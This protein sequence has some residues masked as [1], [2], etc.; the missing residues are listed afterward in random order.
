MH[1]RLTDEAQR[2]L[3]LIANDMECGAR[4]LRD[5]AEGSFVPPPPPPP[6]YDGGVKRAIEEMVIA[7]PKE[8]TIDWLKSYYAESQL[9]VRAALKRF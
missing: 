7:A 5:I 1:I 3:R 8:P 4:T 6:P 9:R 2:A